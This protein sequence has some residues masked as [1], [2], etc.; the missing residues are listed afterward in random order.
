[1]SLPVHTRLKPNFTAIMNNYSVYEVA[2]Y[3]GTNRRDT[4]PAY[5]LLEVGTYRFVKKVS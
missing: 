3:S 4:T 2:V 1:M 5:N